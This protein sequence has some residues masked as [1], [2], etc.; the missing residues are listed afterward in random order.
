MD[1]VGPTTVSSWASPGRGSSPDLSS[2]AR[3]RSRSWAAALLVNVRPRTWSGVA[4]CGGDEVHHPG[5]HQRGLARPG[6]G[7]HHHGL[8]PLGDGGPLLLGRREPRAHQPLQV[9][10][11]VDPHVST[12]PS[13][14]AGQKRSK[15]HQRQWVPGVAANRSSVRAST[16]P[17]MVRSTGSQP[18]GSGCGGCWETTLTA[19]PRALWRSWTSSAPPE[20]L[21][22]RRSS[23]APRVDRELVEAQLRVGEGLLLG[24]RP[25]GG[26]EVDRD[27]PAVDIQLQSVGV[28]GGS[29]PDRPSGSSRRDPDRLLD[30]EQ[31]ATTVRGVPGGEAGQSLLRLVALP[32]RGPG[33]IEAAA[34]ATPGRR[35]P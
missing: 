4:R 20:R 1:T 16:A 34:G 31:L 7:Q 9:L 17:A 11:R 12:R 27:D 33:R 18:S 15:A 28:A 29:R 22:G 13:V 5:S 23:R 32:A 6:A 19:P 24:R 3:T 25:A 35:S 8:Q 2:T 26:L 14:I 21:P 10:R 30:R